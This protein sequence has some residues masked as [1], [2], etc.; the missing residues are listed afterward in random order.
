MD[1][2]SFARE[3]ETHIRPA[4]F[5]VAV[6]LLGTS[7]PLPEKA[8][9]PRRDMN[10]QIAICQAVAMS[11]RYGWTLAVGEEDVN[12]VLTKTAFGL[13]PLTGHYL[14]GNLACGMY[15][16][17]KEAGARTEA[18]TDRLPVGTC[19]YLVTAPAS[20]AEFAPDAVIIY[21]NPAQ[22]MRLV[23]GALWKR[24]GAITSSFTG[25]VD[26]SDEI[27][28]PILSGEYQVILP[29]YGDRVFS[30]TD[31]TE[32]AFSLPGA[33]MAELVEGLEGTH[34][35]GIRYPIPAFLRYTP[36]YPQHYYD[37]EKIWAAGGQTITPDDREK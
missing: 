3:I 21:G 18:A 20:R 32:M 6:K 23:T 15:T 29:C 24:G 27:I 28:R 7:D 22:V 13:A 16:A 1:A 14:E 31:D 17:T 33:K 12:C 9:R 25:R 19:K 5:P 2:K 34:K 8:K 4:T 37:L 35:G 36:Q 11:R 10:V 26:C 30:Q